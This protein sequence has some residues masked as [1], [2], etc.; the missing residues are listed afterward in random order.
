MHFIIP[1]IHHIIILMLQNSVE[2]L[3]AASIC[4]QDW[5]GG[6]GGSK[7]GLEGG[8][9]NDHGRKTFYV[10]LLTSIILYTNT[11]FFGGREMMYS[12]VL[13]IIG[14]AIAPFS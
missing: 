7:S 10:Y 5:G 12:P 13:F 3:A 6:V 11:A 9:K 14:C 2:Q 1:D 4:F 8:A